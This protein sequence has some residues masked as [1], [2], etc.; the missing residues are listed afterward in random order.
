MELPSGFLM[1][2]R[3][4]ERTLPALRK[5]LGLLC[6]HTLLTLP[7]ASAGRV[8]GPFARFQFW[9]ERTARGPDRGELVAAL[10]RVESVAPSLVLRVGDLEPSALLADLVPTLVLA[11]LRARPA[12]F[13]E[14]LLW[15]VPVRRLLDPATG[16]ALTLDPPAKGLLAEANRLE[17]RTATGSWEVSTSPLPGSVREERAF[18]PL[19]EAAAPALALADAN[20]LFM[21]EEH[22]EKSGNAVSLGERSAE[23]WCS[24]LSEALEIVRVCLPALHHEMLETLER[25]VPVGYEP[26]RHLSASYREAPGLVYL[27]LHPSPLTL[28]EALVH[29]TQHGKLNALSWFDP[30][31]E[32]AQTTWT[33][34]PVRPDLRPLWG[35]LLAVHAFVPVAALHLRLAELDHPLS[36]TDLFARRRGDVLAAN[37]DGLATLERLAKPT[38]VGRRVLAAISELHES[39]VAASPTTTSDATVTALG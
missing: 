17:L 33:P 28:A 3:S 11:L 31:L 30:V 19:G 29:E 27:T 20:P 18:F 25:I 22:P 13:S 35:V 14:R 10:G 12:G 34:S 4:G 6:L 7:P 5:K 24:A 1:L 37:R 2:P 39:V 8:Q 9:L 15:D 23:E 16:R 38:D 21:L 36:H 26:E 32:N